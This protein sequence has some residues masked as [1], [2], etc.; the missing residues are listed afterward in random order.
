MLGTL[1]RG[2]FVRL[3]YRL[4]RNASTGA[5]ELGEGAARH[6]CHLRRGY[7]T[8][9]Q[10]E[11]HWA[12]LGEILRDAGAIDD[13]LLARSL[14]AAERGASLQGRA[15]AGS[16]VPLAAIEAALRRQAEL[17]LERLATI[18]QATWSFRPDA[19]SP[20][21]RSAGGVPVA[22]AAWARR[23]AEARLDGARA[24]S[25]AHELAGVRL[26]ARKH[27]LPE[28]ADCDDADRRLIDAM[29]S[30]RRLDELEQI[31]RVPR[32]RLLAFVHFLRTVD[33]VELQ[34]VAARPKSGARP[35]P[36]AEARALLGVSEHDDLD[37]VRRAYR[38]RARE[39]H[40]DVHPDAS[41]KE[42]R[43][44]QARFI[45]ATFAWRTLAKT[46]AAGEGAP[47]QAKASN[48]G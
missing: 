11:G 20:S 3:A 48:L 5:L 42:R 7:V 35:D 16:G 34:G 9:I 40:P 45:A 31:A 46:F 17:R 44:L 15:L 6:L 18:G 27:L 28:P 26:A 37:S 29:A 22:L 4:G 23:H 41:P 30:P 24:R 10:V 33:A 19:P 2:E 36:L 25:L 39:L 13:A 1:T 47:A 43:D 14:A 21:G 8:A 12:P 32:F 38:L